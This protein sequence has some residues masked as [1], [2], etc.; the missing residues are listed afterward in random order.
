MFKLPDHFRILKTLK[1]YCT[2][3]H[4]YYMSLA[5]LIFQALKQELF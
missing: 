2:I 4:S 1:E 5:A 3:R